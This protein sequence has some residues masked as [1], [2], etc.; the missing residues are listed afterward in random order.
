MVDEAKKLKRPNPVKWL[1]GTRA[2]RMIDHL[3]LFVAGLICLLVQNGW[4]TETLERMSLVPKIGIGGI[5]GVIVVIAFISIVILAGFVANFAEEQFKF[6]LCVYLGI[7][8]AGGMGTA[9]IATRNYPFEYSLL[10]WTVTCLV[11]GMFAELVI[12][13]WTKSKPEVP[14][15]N[16]DPD[17]P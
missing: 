2:G 13:P 17:P 3:I 15:L 4:A 10:C 16:K 9:Y 6:L 14:E 5:G 8:L 12:V 7:I 1:V 11:L